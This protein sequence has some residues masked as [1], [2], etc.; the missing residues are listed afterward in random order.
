MP[1]IL[2]QVLVAAML[3]ILIMLSITFRRI[4]FIPITH[5]NKST[6]LRIFRCFHPKQT[7]LVSNKLALLGKV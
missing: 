2:K 3:Q 7:N 5:Y 6:F 4:V 1:L